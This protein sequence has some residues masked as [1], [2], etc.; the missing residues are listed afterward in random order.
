VTADTQEA[1]S[2]L[3]QPHEVRATGCA[4]CE[5]DADGLVADE[6]EPACERCAAVLDEAVDPLVVTDDAEVPDA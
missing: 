5:R 6:R 3:D 4:Y 1:P 2:V